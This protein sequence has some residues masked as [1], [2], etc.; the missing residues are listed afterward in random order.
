MVEGE[1]AE[2]KKRQESWRGEPS[3]G[4]VYF[5]EVDAITAKSKWEAKKQNRAFNKFKELSRWKLDLGLTKEA[6]SGKCPGFA[7]GLQR[8]VSQD[9]GESEAT[10]SLPGSPASNQPISTS[11]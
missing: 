10:L 2:W 5:L 1:R 7:L 3:I 11:D 8:G 6:Q 4:A 9:K